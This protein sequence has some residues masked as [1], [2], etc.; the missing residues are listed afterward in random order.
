MAFARFV[1]SSSLISLPQSRA[2]PHPAMW[3]RYKH[4][5]CAQQ[6]R[7]K[8]CHR[9]MCEVLSL[10]A[11]QPPSKLGRRGELARESAA[12]HPQ[13]SAQ[14]R[15]VAKITAQ[16]LPTLRA[17][18]RRWLGSATDQAVLP[19]SQEEPLRSAARA[20]LP[21]VVW[22]DCAVERRLMDAQTPR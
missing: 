11:R 17:T 4:Q 22:G 3:H 20:R 5:P 13:S 6:D 8:F 19:T 1:A 21:R 9:M 18:G 10:L 7:R 16:A 15:P 14:G 12:P 2:R